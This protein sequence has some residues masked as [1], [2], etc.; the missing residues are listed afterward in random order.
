MIKFSYVLLGS[1]LALMSCGKSERETPGGF[2]YSLVKAGSGAEPKKGEIMV[3]DFE[4]RDSKDSVWNDSY[5]D[6]MPAAIEK[7]DTSVLKNADGITE[8][9]SELKV[10]D[11]VRASMTTADFF[12]NLVKRPMP[13]TIDS[14]LTLTY[15]IKVNEVMTLENFM[16]WRSERIIK[17]EDKMINDYLTKNNLEAEKDTS[18]LYIVNH[19]NGAGPKPTVDNCVEVKYNGK[20]LQNGREFDKNESVSF[21]LGQVIRGWQIA[22]PKLAKGDSATILIPSRLGY[23]AEGY[24]GIPPDA[25]LLFDVTL[26]DFKSGFDPATNKCK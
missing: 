2:K 3:F 24:Y 9:L 25:V 5:K 10:G 20:F 15:S 26:R 4:L 14:T 7:Q 6:G 17:K 12:K 13:P 11:S 18:G 23:G 16:K 22:F 8:M 21:N 1:L 19:V